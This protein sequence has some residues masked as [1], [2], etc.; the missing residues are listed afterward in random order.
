MEFTIKLS[1]S[2]ERE[3]R[4][5]ATSFGIDNIGEY[6]LEKMRTVIRL[7]ESE[8][9]RD[10]METKVLS[11]KQKNILKKFAGKYFERLTEAKVFFE[12]EEHF[13]I[14]LKAKLKENNI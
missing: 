7:E 6:L 1:R 12:N 13:L 9:I 2:Q 3:L 8:S 11:T 14:R 10:I 5:E 4:K